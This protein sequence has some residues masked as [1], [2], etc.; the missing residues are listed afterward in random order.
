MKKY[1]LTM[2]LAIPLFA[3]AQ[4]ALLKK[5]FKPFAGLSVIGGVQNNK[6][7]KGSAPVF[8]IEFSM[9]CP[10]IQSGK[11]RVRQ[12]ITLMR[13]EQKDYRSLTI[14]INP[15]YKLIAGPSF[16]LGIGPV[17]GFIFTPVRD[18]NKPVFNYGLGTSAMYYFKRVFIG[19][20]SRYTL[21]KNILLGDMYYE[22]TI[23]EKANLNSLRGFLKL[24]YKLLK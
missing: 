21:T 2:I 11:S 5:E 4:D 1:L 23:A 6:Y 12:Q 8:G 7:F 15:H 19:L 14:E 22:T 17:A 9:E 16:E 18:N 3:M 20:E 10:L 13:Q 24:G